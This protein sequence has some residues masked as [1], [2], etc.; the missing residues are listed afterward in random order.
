MSRRDRLTISGLVAALIVVTILVA[1]PAGELPAM[2]TPTPTDAAPTPAP[3]VYREGVI[4]AWSSLTP[5]SART[6]ADREIVSLVFSGLVR[7]GREG[8]LL[9]DLAA[10]WKVEEDGARYT[11]RIRPDEI[12]RAHV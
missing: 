3:T 6:T 7:L 12:G 10:D 2:S 11:F 5:I 8:S 4:G 9:P 1:L